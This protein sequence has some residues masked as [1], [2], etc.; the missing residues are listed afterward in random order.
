MYVVIYTVGVDAGSA[1]Q[2]IEFVL[3]SP[4]FCGTLDHPFVLKLKC[5]L[6]CPFSMWISNTA[7]CTLNQN[8]HD[9][10]IVTKGCESFWVQW[11][12]KTIELMD[13]FMTT[14]VRISFSLAR[15]KHL[16]TQNRKYE[17]SKVIAK[18]Q[19]E[20]SLSHWTCCSEHFYFTQLTQ[21]SS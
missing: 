1:S 17:I 19:A 4:S 9:L 21:A 15:Y 12:V 7:F 13:K 6:P 16:M 5:S 3:D 11:W 20:H 18:L 2:K 8:C 14:F 10:M